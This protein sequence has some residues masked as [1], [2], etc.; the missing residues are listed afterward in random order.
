MSRANWFSIT[1][2]L[3]N[4]I[5]SREK[6]IEQLFK[7]YQC[8]DEFFIQTLVYKSLY[9]EKLYNQ[10]FADDYNGCLQYI[11]WK[12]GNPYILRLEDYRN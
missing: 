11:D 2:N 4:Y 6:W 9:K 12:R 1:N 10:N 5:I 7:C 3:V 8:G